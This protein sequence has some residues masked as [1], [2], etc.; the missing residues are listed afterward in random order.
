MRSFIRI[1]KPALKVKSTLSQTHTDVPQFVRHS[2]E[3]LVSRRQL[4]AERFIFI[5]SVD[6]STRVFVDPSRPDAHARRAARLVLHRT[7][8]HEVDDPD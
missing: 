7:A 8:A 2:M 4:N 3:K 6:S 5:S 1:L